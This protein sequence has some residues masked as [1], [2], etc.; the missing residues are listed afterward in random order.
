[1]ERNTIRERVLKGREASRNKGRYAGGQVRYGYRLSDDGTLVNDHE[2]VPAINEMTRWCRDGDSRD[3]IADRLNQLGFH[4]PNDR[5]M[6]GGLGVIEVS[7]AHHIAEAYRLET[8][9]PIPTSALRITPRSFRH[10]SRPAS[11]P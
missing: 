7:W 4:S 11:S 10:T 2:V 1:M 9:H 8:G 5:Y 3:V 6:R